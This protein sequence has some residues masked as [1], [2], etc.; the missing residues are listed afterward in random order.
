MSATPEPFDVASERRGLIK[1]AAAHFKALVSADAVNLEANLRYARVQLVIGDG[2]LARQYL[3]DARRLSADPA[4]QY[5]SQLLEGVS[6]ENDGQMERAETAYRAALAAVPGARSAATRLAALLFVKGQAADARTILDA[7]LGPDQASVDP[8]V[9]F[10]AGDG[11]RATSLLASL[12]TA[13]K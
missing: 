11:H 10:A 6:W 5:V 3:A 12:R 1:S 8:W 4:A 2:S 7:S 9:T 13:L